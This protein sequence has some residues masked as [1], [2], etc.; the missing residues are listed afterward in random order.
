MRAATLSIGDELALGQVED[1]NAA[2][3]A[4]RLAAEGLFRDEHR[5]VGD[6]RDAIA[7]ALAAL[8][9]DRSL[10]VATGG[11]GPTE[12]D[13]T[14][15]A[16][17]RVLDL[18]A[19]LVEDPDARR[20]LDRWF[21]DRGRAMPASNLVQALRPRSARCLANEQG[22]APGL[23]ATHGSTTIVCLPGPPRE[24]RPLF[25]REV[26]PLARAAAGGT[27]MPMTV[28]HAFGMGESAL[29]ERLG[30][31][32]ARGAT[33]VVGTTASRSIVSARIRGRGP[34]GAAE[35]AVERAA[36]EV[37]RRWHP[38]AYGRERT[39][40]A[41]SVLDLLVDRR[42]TLAVAESCTGGLLAAALTDRPG[43]SAAFAGGWIVYSNDLKERLLGVPRSTLAA[44]G[45]VSEAVAADVA[46][47]ARA[48][49]RTV[50]GLGITGIAGPEGG[51]PTKPVGTV[52]IGLSGPAGTRVRRFHFPG[53]RDVVR[54]R[55]MKSALQWLR[56][57][58]LG[59]ENAPLFWAHADPP[60][61]E[62]P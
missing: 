40:L 27:T 29:A 25:E 39:T 8:A 62:T 13:L 21:R 15:A 58:L 26:V 18:E 35:T 49:A 32:M 33:P 5:T 7:D 55:A 50:W 23:L 20:A 14:R 19:P 37:E 52:F 10:V 57:A 28:V 2:W 30:P 1:T 47:S 41:A 36:R 45:A 24:M 53:E 51:S 56:F 46:T 38:Y 17:N 4:D 48:T 12:D 16:L 22:T 44:H 43:S 6:D 54:D 61:S 11:L 9:R 3:I 59:V 60:R 42:E 31:L 34:A